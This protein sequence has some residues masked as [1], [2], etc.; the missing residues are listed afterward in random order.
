MNEYRELLSDSV[1]FY[2]RYYDA[3]VVNIVKRFIDAGSPPVYLMSVTSTE[4]L[5]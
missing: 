2:D 5:A 3:M 4:Y 1:H